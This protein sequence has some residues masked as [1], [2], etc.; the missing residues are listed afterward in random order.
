MLD[1]YI[2]KALEIAKYK[3]L[4]DSSWYAD[5]DGFQGVWANGITVEEC[6]RELKE[7]LE[8]WL[9]LK[10]RDGDIIPPIKGTEIRIRE[11]LTVK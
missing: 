5:I 7:V 6:R 4:E 1:E 10:I 8:E 3:Y 9:L 11:P 2:Q